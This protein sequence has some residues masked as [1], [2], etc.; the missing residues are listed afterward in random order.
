MTALL[1]LAKYM[2]MIAIFFAN[3]TLVSGQECN[4]KVIR[5]QMLA[6]KAMEKV[7]TNDTTLGFRLEFGN[8]VKVFHDD[9]LITEFATSA[10]Y[11]TYKQE[12]NRSGKKIQYFLL[13]TI[14]SENYSRL[15][16]NNEEIRQIE[17][18]LQAADYNYFQ[19]AIDDGDILFDFS[20]SGEMKFHLGIIKNKIF[21]DGGEIPLQ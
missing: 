1:K 9:Q 11:L 16:I 13:I 8:K 19:A 10:A 17:P 12:V 3:S 15:F 18:R 20:K 4:S 6:A 21:C 14:G 2:L 7:K 5:Q